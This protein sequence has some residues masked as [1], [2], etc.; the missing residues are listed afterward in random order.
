MAGACPRPATQ[1]KVC[2]SYGVLWN[3]FKRLAGRGI[4]MLGVSPGEK[5][6]IFYETAVRVYGLQLPPTAESTL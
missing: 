5:A 1:D 6:Q 4:G 3:A 2:V